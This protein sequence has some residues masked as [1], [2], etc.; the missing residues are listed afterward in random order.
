MASGVATTEQYDGAQE[1]RPDH[2]EGLSDRL[3]TR[4]PE[5]TG[6]KRIRTDFVRDANAGSCLHDIL[7]R[8]DFRSPVP[9]LTAKQSLNRFGIDESA[10]GLSDWLTE[11][12]VAP[13]PAIETASGLRLNAIAPRDAIVELDFLLPIA[14]AD[15]AEI[16]RAVSK[17]YPVVGQF[18]HLDQLA[19]DLVQPMPA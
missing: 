11:V 8:V 13:L 18:E 10:Q 3:M 19:V 6:N 12:L 2:D 15:P 14:S 9:P 1:L 7:E 4:V 16:V 17:H 5:T